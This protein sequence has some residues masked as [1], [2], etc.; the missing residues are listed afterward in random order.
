MTEVDSILFV[1][2]FE[3]LEAGRSG[4]SWRA[5]NLELEL[6]I[7]SIIELLVAGS[8]LELG[9]MRQAIIAGVKW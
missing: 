9:P 3:S 2:Q 6:V 7:I 5:L 8:E 1:D 4:T